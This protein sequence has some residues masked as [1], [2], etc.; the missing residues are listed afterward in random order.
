M[1]HTLTLKASGNK[2]CTPS[3]DPWKPR[4]GRAVTIVN[5]SGYEQTLASITAGL[6]TP[7]PGNAITVTTTENWEGTVGRS[8]GTYVYNDGK[9]AKE[10]RNGTIDPS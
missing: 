3:E 10:P 4:R 6:L 1:S 9:A 2:G 8:A 7:A 5:K